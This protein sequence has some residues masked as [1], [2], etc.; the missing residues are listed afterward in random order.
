MQT[1]GSQLLAEYARPVEGLV[2]RCH[3]RVL[4]KLVVPAPRPIIW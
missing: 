3:D 1:L 2:D 4:S